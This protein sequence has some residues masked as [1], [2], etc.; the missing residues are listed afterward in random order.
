[1]NLKELAAKEGISYEAAKKR[2][3]RGLLSIVPDVPVGAFPC[4]RCQELETELAELRDQLDSLQG[5]TGQVS[6][7]LAGDEFFQG[8]ASID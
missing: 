8:E 2:K 4:P 5:K 3:Q 6:S 1:M 7:S